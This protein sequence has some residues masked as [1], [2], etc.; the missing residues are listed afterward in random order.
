M[1]ENKKIN[2]QCNELGGIIMVSG[3]REPGEERASLGGMED[4]TLEVVL[5]GCIV[6][7]RHQRRWRGGDQDTQKIEASPP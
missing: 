4:V 1:W 5:E 2:M 3:K 6:L 7:T